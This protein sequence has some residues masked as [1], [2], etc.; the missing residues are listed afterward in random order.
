ML[1]ARKKDKIEAEYALR[2][3]NK[4]MGISEY[5]LTDAIPEKIK[6]KLPSIEELEIK[7]AERIEKPS[8][9][10]NEEAKVR[11]KTVA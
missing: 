10:R 2:D 11:K 9:N 4:P 7:L 3:I 8:G 1:W 6:T 5:R